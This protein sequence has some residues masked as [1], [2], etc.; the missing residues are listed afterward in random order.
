MEVKLG[1]KT[2][3]VRTLTMG[4]MSRVAKLLKEEGSTDSRG[5][6]GREA[7]QECV[8]EINATGERVALDPMVLAGLEDEDLRTLA[9]AVASVNKAKSLPPEGDVY[10]SLGVVLRD[11]LDETFASVATMTKKAMDQLDSSLGVS[12]RTV[13]EDN[14]KHLSVL[15]QGIRATDAFHEFQRQQES[16]LDAVAAGRTLT[17]GSG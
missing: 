8:R 16:A 10:E 17:T 4:A 15:Q 12:L 11:R 9:Q 1:Q 13:L 5:A 3:N 6:Y 14:F 2:F 7:F